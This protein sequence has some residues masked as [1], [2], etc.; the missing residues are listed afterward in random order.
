MGLGASLQRLGD[1]LPR[2]LTRNIQLPW[3]SLRMLAPMGMLLL[4]PALLLLALGGCSAKL[5]PGTIPRDRFDYSGAIVRS[6]KEQMLL[7]M[8]RVRYMDPPV[9]LDVQQVVQQYTLEG[10]GAISAPGWTGDTTIAPAAAVAGRWAESPTITY[11][12]LN[13]DKFSKGLLQP[14]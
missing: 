4:L 2:S 11:L 13:G 9:F 7:N 1:A 8:V 10:T 12:P 3:P 14:V 5:G 6:W